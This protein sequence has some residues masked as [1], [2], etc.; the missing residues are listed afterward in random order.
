MDPLKEPLYI[1]VR[2]PETKL[3]K[4][5]TQALP[6]LPPFQTEL[7]Q[8]FPS[9]P[10]ARSLWGLWGQGFRRSHSDNPGEAYRSEHNEVK[11]N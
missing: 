8:V 11:L 5:R 7:E 3:L 10:S 9:D 4:L 2:V 6:S 1:L